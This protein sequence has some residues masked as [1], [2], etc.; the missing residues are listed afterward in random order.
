MNLC[1]NLTVLVKWSKTLQA[2]NQGSYIV[3][4]CINN[5]HICPWHNFQVFTSMYPVGHNAP[6]FSTKKVI[7]SESM[8]R[9]HLKQVL[10]SI[11]LDPSIYTFHTFRRSGATLA[12]N[13]DIDMDHIKRHG[14]WRSDAVKTYIIDDPH[15]ASAVAS[16]MSRFFDQQP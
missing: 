5:S 16:S 2:T 9:K 13:L 11:G 3:L 8:M 7:I 1:F 4:P 10:E 14:T 12:H 15:R 6:C